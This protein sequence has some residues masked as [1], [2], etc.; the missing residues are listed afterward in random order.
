[1]VPRTNLSDGLERAPSFLLSPVAL[2]SWQTQSSAPSAAPALPPWAS[3]GLVSVAPSCPHL[4]QAS[5]PIS[6]S[7]STPSLRMTVGGEGM[8]MAHLTTT[9]PVS[10]LK[11]PQLCS[12][13]WGCELHQVAHPDVT[14]RGFPQVPHLPHGLQVCTQRPRPPLHPAS[15]LPHAAS[16]VRPGMGWRGLGQGGLGPEGAGVCTVLSTCTG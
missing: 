7:K 10:S 16:Q 8:E 4:A 5:P 3:R 9:P 1:M 11:V 2:V 14:L 6:F 12:G 13:V 15:Q